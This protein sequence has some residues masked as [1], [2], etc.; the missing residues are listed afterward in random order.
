MGSPNRGRGGE[1]PRTSTAGITKIG[2]AGGE[3]TRMSR[4]KI[5][6]INAQRSKK[7]RM[8]NHPT[9]LHVWREGKDL[10]QITELVGGALHFKKH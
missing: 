7:G 6:G 9:L 2:G 10:D 3:T 8:A 1:A 4:A 5:E